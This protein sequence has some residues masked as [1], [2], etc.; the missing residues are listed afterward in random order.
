M[1]N[2]SYYPRVTKTSCLFREVLPWQYL[3]AVDALFAAAWQV[4]R[5]T[6]HQRHKLPRSLKDSRCFVHDGSLPP[7][8]RQ[9]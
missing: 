4:I 9:V 1:D 5:V 3:T 6:T 2:A 8:G 7:T